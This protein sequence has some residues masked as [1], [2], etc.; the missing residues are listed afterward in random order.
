MQACPPSVLDKPGPSMSRRRV[1]VLADSRHGL[2]EWHAYEVPSLKEE[3][4]IGQVSKA[5]PSIVEE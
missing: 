2:I 3:C 4:L 5:E 1:Y